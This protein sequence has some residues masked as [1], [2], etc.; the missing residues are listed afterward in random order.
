MVRFRLGVRSRQRSIVFCNL[1][2]SSLWVDFV[3]MHSSIRIKNALITCLL[4]HICLL[5]WKRC[6]VD[7]EWPWYAIDFHIWSIYSYMCTSI[8]EYAHRL[9]WF[10]KS[11]YLHNHALDTLWQWKIV[12]LVQYGFSFMKLITMKCLNCDLYYSNI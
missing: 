9:G 5:Y 2:F 6:F 3:I 11:T 1:N 7:L 4:C 10:V 12:S 8:F